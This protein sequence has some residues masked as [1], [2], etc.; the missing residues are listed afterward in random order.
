[1]VRAIIILNAKV[2]APKR[3]VYRTRT[4]TKTKVIVLAIYVFYTERLVIALHPFDVD[5]TWCVPIS[6]HEND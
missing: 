5:C 6:P 4:P 1:M 2:I 3:P